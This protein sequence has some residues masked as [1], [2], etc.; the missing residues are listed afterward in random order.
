MTL[1]L[2]DL[3][4][5]KEVYAGSQEMRGLAVRPESSDLLFRPQVM[6]GV[7]AALLALYSMIAFLIWRNRG[8]F[9]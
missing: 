3:E 8:Y 9:F 7:L 5:V 4:G 2:S 6:Y 1:A